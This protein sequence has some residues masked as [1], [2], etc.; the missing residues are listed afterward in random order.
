MGQQVLNYF[1]QFPS[2]IL[3]VDEIN[4]RRV[5]SGLR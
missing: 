5:E 4:L 1:L 3:K 2:L